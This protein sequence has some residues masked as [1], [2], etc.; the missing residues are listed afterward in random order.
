MSEIQQGD[1]ARRIAQVND[2]L[3][4]PAET[5]W[6][7]FKHN[8]ADPDRIGRTVAALSNSARLTDQAFAYMVWGIEDATRRILGTTFVPAVA[9]HSGTLGQPLELWLRNA[10]KPDTNIEFFTVRY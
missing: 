10:I 3:K 5:E 2:L 9:R 1:N 8:N 6:A 4:L 7:E